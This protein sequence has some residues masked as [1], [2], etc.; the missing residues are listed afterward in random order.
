MEFA[1]YKLINYLIRYKT[2]SAHYQVC[3][4]EAVKIMSSLQDN[5]GLSD[6]ELL[7]VRNWLDLADEARDTSNGTDEIVTG[8]EHTRIAQL[9][10][11]LKKVPDIKTCFVHLGEVYIIN[12]ILQ[13]IL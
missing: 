2:S 3:T 5:D 7:A 13:G 12:L 4:E 8:H 11:Q 6:D 10:R 1:Q 9:E